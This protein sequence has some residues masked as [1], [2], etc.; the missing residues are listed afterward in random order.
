MLRSPARPLSAELLAL[1]L[2]FT[3]ERLSALPR[4]MWMIQSVST[5]RGAPI[6][7]PQCPAAVSNCLTLYKL[8]KLQSVT[9]KDGK[10][11][12]C[13]A[14]PRSKSWLY[15]ALSRL[16][17]LDQ[18]QNYGITPEPLAEFVVRTN[19]EVEAHAAEFE[20]RAR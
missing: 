4:M 20:R 18:L 6:G 17:S 2:R 12:L 10:L 5:W 11:Y 1:V 14:D 15:V 19:P 7:R 13:R 8:Y 3:D 16:E 9:L